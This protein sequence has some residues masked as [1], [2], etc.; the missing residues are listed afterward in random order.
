[1][2]L[3]P[4]PLLATACCPPSFSFSFVCYF[5][6]SLTGSIGSPQPHVSPLSVTPLLFCLSFFGVVSSSAPGVFFRLI[7]SHLHFFFCLLFLFTHSFSP[8]LLQEYTTK[9]ER[10]CAGAAYL[11]GC[12]SAVLTLAR[13]RFDARDGW[14]QRRFFPGLR[15]YRHRKTVYATKTGV[16][17][18]A[19]GIRK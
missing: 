3:F 17:V 12:V 15:R 8:P 16:L 9:K 18:Q 6:T 14:N 19:R 7:V 5:H 11:I 1:M 2:A 4:S 10:P 13:S